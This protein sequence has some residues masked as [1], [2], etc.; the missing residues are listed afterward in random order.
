MNFERIWF[1]GEKTPAKAS[2]LQILKS[3][4]GTP[5]RANSI[6]KNK[7]HYKF[8]MG[9]IFLTLQN[10]TQKKSMFYSIIFVST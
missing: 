7:A 3:K 1:A 10:E 2:F 5:T 9:F 6:T 4:E 8:T